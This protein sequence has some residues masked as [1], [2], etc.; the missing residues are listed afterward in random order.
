MQHMCL[1]KK[2]HL[3]ALYLHIQFDSLSE[4]D[5]QFITGWMSLLS[6][7]TYFLRLLFILLLYYYAYVISYMFL[8]RI[9]WSSE[10]SHTI[11]GA[12]KITQ[13][14]KYLLM[15]LMSNVI[16]LYNILLLLHLSSI[17]V[18]TNKDRSSFSPFNRKR[19]V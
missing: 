13:S 19:N 3:S 5:I 12:F 1:S 8:V 6:L 15:I 10:S 11:H 16:C 7:L 18:P 9:F 4:K 14:I 17:Y 2:I